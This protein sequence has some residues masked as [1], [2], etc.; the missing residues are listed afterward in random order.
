MKTGNGYA[1]SN[2]SASMPGERDPKAKCRFSSRKSCDCSAIIC[3]CT[4]KLESVNQG[5]RPI[6]HETQ[7]GIHGMPVFAKS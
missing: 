7:T 4:V 5:Q 1:F 3:D 6:A 2:V